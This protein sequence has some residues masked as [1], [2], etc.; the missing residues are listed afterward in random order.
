MNREH[1]FSHNN[2]NNKKKK[3]KK[4]MCN[5]NEIPIPTDRRSHKRIAAVRRK[6]KGRRNKS[7][8]VCSWF[9]CCLD[10]AVSFPFSVY[11]VWLFF[12][13]KKRNCCKR[14]YD[15][16]KWKNKAHG[17]ARH[18]C[19]RRRRRV[20]GH[21]RRRQRRRQTDISSRDHTTRQHGKKTS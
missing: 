11:Y 13:I 14:S 7:V 15:E 19:R 9:T 10:G 2:N 20:V 3:K 4:K 1:H 5:K 18:V 16:K 8:H 12:D 21:K 6:E 17:T